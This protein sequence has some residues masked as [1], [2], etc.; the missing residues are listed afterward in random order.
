MRRR[1]FLV[2][3]ISGGFALSGCLSQNQP[4]S[5]TSTP[6]P[7]DNASFIVSGDGEYPHNIRVENSLNRDVTLT[8]GVERDGTIIYQDT[9]TVD[10]QTTEVVAGITEESLPEDSR[11]VTVSATTSEGQAHSEVS[12]S[13]CLGDVYFL[14]ESDGTLQSTYSIC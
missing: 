13:D 12:I 1:A 6:T 8:I 5:T 4:S 10:A 14:Y 9:F 3:T 2:T 11:S 7:I